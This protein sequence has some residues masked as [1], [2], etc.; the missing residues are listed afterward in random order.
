MSKKEFVSKVTGEIWQKELHGRWNRVIHHTAVLLEECSSVGK[1]GQVTVLPE[2]SRVFIDDIRGRI[3]PQFRVRDLS[4]KIWFIPVNKLKVLQ[5][6]EDTKPIDDT[7]HEYRG[8]VRI[9]KDQKE[10]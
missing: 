8:G 10:I 6:E 1:N 4:G 5:N 9:D 7:T 2:D 3:N